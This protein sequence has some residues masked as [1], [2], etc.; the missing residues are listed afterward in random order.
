MRGLLWLGPYISPLLYLI[1]ND[2]TERPCGYLFAFPAL[3]ADTGLPGR[4][5]HHDAPT[6]HERG[7]RPRTKP[8]RQRS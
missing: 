6:V 7:G 1:E 3:G 2:G 8:W 5:A 4:T